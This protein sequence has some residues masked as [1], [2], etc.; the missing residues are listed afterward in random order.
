MK[1]GALLF[2]GLLAALL[3]SWGGVVL[4]ANGQLGGL[5]PYYDDNDSQS[6]PLRLPGAASAGQL[7]YRDLNCAAC[8]TQQVRR[9]DFG[10]DIARGWGER[11]SVARDYIYQPAVQLGQS[12]LGPDLA[13]LAGRK[14]SALDA[15]DLYT[16]LY[17]G[18]GAM[19][20][21]SFL[22]DDRTVVGQVSDQALAL[23]GR[24]R[25]KAGR[26]IVPT[27]QAQELVAYLL[28]LNS[29]YAYPEARPA[30]PAAGEKKAE[31]KK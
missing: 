23:V 21:Y 20:A 11:Q 2:L 14:P 30:A 12:R 7:V 9:E 6:Y 27:R 18:H 31:A 8:H 26:E 25:A 16:L 15:T 24:Y 29:S 17:E 28:S 10:S 3:L 19:P 4:G 1:N 13:N 5:S 22:F